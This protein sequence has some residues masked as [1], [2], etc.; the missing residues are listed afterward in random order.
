[1]KL[2]ESIK[3]K[4]CLTE[5]TPNFPL[6][7]FVKWAEEANINIPL[8]SVLL[9]DIQE[10]LDSVEFVSRQSFNVSSHQ[11]I[12]SYWCL[13]CSQIRSYYKAIIRDLDC[14]EELSFLLR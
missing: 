9:D 3:G 11:I 5:I 7:G 4:I 8:L 12:K 14:K 2:K 13:Y 1:M 10:E 6:G